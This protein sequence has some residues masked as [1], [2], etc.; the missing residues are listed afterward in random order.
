ML[1]DRPRRLLPDLRGGGR[2]GARLLRR[3]PDPRGVPRPG[4]SRTASATACGAA[5]PSSSAAGCSA[6]SPDVLTPRLGVA[7]APRLPLEPTRRSTPSRRC[8]SASSAAAPISRTGTRSTAAPCSPRRSTIRARP[9]HAARGPR[10]RGPLARPRTPGRVPPRR[11]ARV[12]RR[13]GP[14]EGRD[15]ARWAHDRASTSRSAAKRRPAAAWAVRRRSSP[16]SS[17]RSRCSA[18]RRLGASELARTVVPDRTRGPRDQRR[19]AGPV[20]RRV[21]RLQPARVLAAPASRVEPVDDRA[22]RRTLADGLLLCYTG[23]VRRNVGLIDRQIALHRR[24]SRGDARS[25]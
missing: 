19:L 22:A 3:L 13:D 20:R 25:G 6:T 8:G 21:R 14:A 12:R 17:P 5:R 15:R 10:G 7:M 24:G 11:G 4:R 1:R 2:A 18:E 16:P 23:H 9:D